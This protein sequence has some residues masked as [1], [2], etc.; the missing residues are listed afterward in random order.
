M[1]VDPKALEQRLAAMPGVLARELRTAMQTFLILV[2]GDA[3]LGA[4]RD[5]GRLAGSISHSIRGTGLDI[6]GT[7]GPSARYGAAQ[8]FG[9]HFPGKMP[10]VDALIPWVRRHPLGVLP[11]RGASRQSA[12]RSQAFL[13]ARAIKRR[14]L[15]ARPYM[16]PAYAKNRPA[17]DALFHRA[18]QRTTDFLRTGQT[19]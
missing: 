12:L 14:G 19:V 8:E 4:P 15:R 5:I 1:S 16:Q 13:L 10:P 9:A 3:R 2:E 17:A 11:R 18:A 6:S 7:V